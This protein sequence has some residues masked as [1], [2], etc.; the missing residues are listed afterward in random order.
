MSPAAALALLVLHTSAL[1]AAPP[2]PDCERRPTWCQPGY[3]CVP[4]A[5]AAEAAVQLTLLTAEVDVLHRKRQK[6]LGW[7][8]VC[9]PAASL[10]VDDSQTTFDGTLSCAVG[11]G[12]RFP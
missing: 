11:F 6:A 10:S 5:C 1:T 3:V 9:G 7:A 12:F 2:A 4:T 8:A